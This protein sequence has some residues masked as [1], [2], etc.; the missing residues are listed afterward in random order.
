[1]TIFNGTI[2]NL[3]YVSEGSLTNDSST[4]LSV[5]FIATTSTVLSPGVVTLGA[6]RIGASAIRPVV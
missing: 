3:T 6:S 1:M 4:Q 2:T 5:D